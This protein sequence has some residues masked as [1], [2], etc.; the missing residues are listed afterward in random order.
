MEIKLKDIMPVM[1]DKNGT[2]VFIKHEDDKYPRREAM[3]ARD[4]LAEFG[5]C[6]VREVSPFIQ[7]G[8][9]YMGNVYTLRAKEA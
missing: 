1:G 4:A 6:A 7:E 8:G 3:T 5:K 9:E 2:I